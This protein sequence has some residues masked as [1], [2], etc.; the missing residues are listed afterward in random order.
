MSGLFFA[1]FSLFLCA[2]ARNLRRP[3]EA[4]IQNFAFFPFKHVMSAVPSNKFRL[5][6]ARIRTE[7]SQKTS[8]SASMLF[9]M[10]PDL[11]NIYDF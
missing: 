5:K 11:L 7:S 2:F 3:I 8:I 4:L 1:V 9:I 6:F 10:R